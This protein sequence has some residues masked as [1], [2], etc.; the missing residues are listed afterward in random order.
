MV[1][2]PEAT[3]MSI[4]VDVSFLNRRIYEQNIHMSECQIEIKF[5]TVPIYLRK[6]DTE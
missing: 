4:K 1:K 5:S 6:I 3:E 2:A